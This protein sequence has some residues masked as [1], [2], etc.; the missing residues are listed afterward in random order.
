MLL[1]LEMMVALRL[2]VTS[3]S[4][5]S[6]Q[7]YHTDLGCGVVRH[8]LCCDDSVP[9]TDAVCVP[10]PDSRHWRMLHWTTSSTESESTTPTP[11]PLIHACT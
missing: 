6:V 10:A 8:I 5:F 7:G 11:H 4:L 9:I 2:L 1:V 3:I